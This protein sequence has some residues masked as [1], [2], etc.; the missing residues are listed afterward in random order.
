MYKGKMIRAERILIP[1]IG[2]ITLFPIEKDH[3]TAKF[4]ELK[5]LKCENSLE[6]VR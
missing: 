3:F 5:A 4:V 6:R 1:F 2:H